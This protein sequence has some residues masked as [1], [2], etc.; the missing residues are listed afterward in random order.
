MIIDIFELEKRK[1]QQNK[2][3][4][5]NRKN[6]LDLERTSFQYFKKQPTDPLFKQ[7]VLKVQKV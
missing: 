5:Q 4:S 1:D 6:V 3:T 7:R 2:W